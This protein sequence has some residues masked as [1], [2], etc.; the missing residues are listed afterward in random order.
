MKF[1]AKVEYACL[2][3]IALARHRQ[4][5]PPIRARVIAEG[6]HIPENYLA[7]ILLQLKAAGLVFSTRGAA[8]GYRLARPAESISLGEVL[9]AIEGP[10]DPPRDEPQG[11]ASQVLA[12]VLEHLR[13]AERTVLDQ[14]SMA[15]LAER[16]APHEW[17]I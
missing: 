4:E 2:A 16:S 11:L 15:Q 1:S 13:A 12:S 9:S 10:Q 5:D 14:T 8:G 7:Q 17:V 3:I 6:Y